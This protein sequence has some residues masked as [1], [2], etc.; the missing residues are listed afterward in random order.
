MSPN[1]LKLFRAFKLSWKK[2]F[3]GSTHFDTHPF[4]ST[5]WPKLSDLLQGIPWWIISFHDLTSRSG[6]MC[7]YHFTH[8]DFTGSW[9]MCFC[10]KLLELLVF[11]FFRGIFL[12][13]V[14]VLHP[15]MTWAT[16]QFALT[17]LI[18]PCRAAWC[19]GVPPIRL[20]VVRFQYSWFI[21]I[22]LFVVL[23]SCV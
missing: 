16:P 7:N 12:H 1:P 23:L 3:V 21:G 10:Y 18:R 6:W 17:M 5:S 19:R 14:P 15:V 8:P 4:G 11:A 13:N 9:R 22:L 20:A 2:P